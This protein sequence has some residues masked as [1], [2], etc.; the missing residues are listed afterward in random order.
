MEP[1]NNIQS[2]VLKTELINWR[3]LQFIQ[4]DNFKELPPDARHKLKASIVANNFTQPFY[5]WEDPAGVKWCLDGKHRTLLLEELI[6]ESV[7]IPYELPATFI[8]CENK[9]EA[10]KLVLIYSSIYAKITQEGLFDF[11]KLNELVFD[12]LKMEM[13]LPEFKIETFEEK[14]F[15]ENPTAELDNFKIQDEIITDIVEGDLFEIGPHR[16]LCGDS[17]SNKDVATLMNKQKSELLFTSPP[18]S[19]MRD[20]NGGK[21]LSIDK[22]IK[23]ISA[24]K[25]YSKYQ[26][27]NLG[28]QRKDNEINSYWDKYIE[29]ARSCGYKFLSWNVWV[30]QSAGS[31]GNQSAFI[32]IMHE[33][34]FV[35]GEAFKD[36]KRTVERKTK[37]NNDIKNKMV[38][39]PDGSK[40]KSSAGFQDSL[41]QMESV[42][43]CPTETGSITSLHPATFPVKLPSEYIKSITNKKDIITEPF[44]GSGTTM[45]A[46]H[47]LERICYTMELDPKFCQVIIDRMKQLFP[48]LTIKKNGTLVQ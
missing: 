23:F 15:T 48:D 6:N 5:I 2:R 7:N 28:I 17:T 36:V 20:Y 44:G 43:Y 42:I 19:D 27:I 21:D 45:V 4:N 8:H 40:K 34:I 3:E 37:P 9:K 29:K 35:F 12:E 26:A 24:F 32:P 1:N 33:W 16:L 46:S 25:P 10:S 22:L 47:I 38:R 11:V 14:F 18:Y 31:I 39:Q 13:D 30:K 41:K